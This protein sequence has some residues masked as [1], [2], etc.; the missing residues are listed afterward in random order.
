MSD[1]I[2]FQQTERRKWPRRSVMASV[3]LNVLNDRKK[4]ESRTFNI[5]EGGLC[6]GTDK[7]INPLKRVDINV[8][9]SSELPLGERY[10]GKVVW[11]QAVGDL[12]SGIYRYGIKFE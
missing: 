4:Y 11:G 5:S 12:N 10:S 1:F 9:L 8:V 3:S 7:K 6:I 2:D